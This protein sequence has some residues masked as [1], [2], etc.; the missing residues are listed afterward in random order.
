MLKK[1]PYK[2]FYSAVRKLY[3][4]EVTVYGPYKRKSDGRAIA[5]VYS[6]I[7]GVKTSITKLYAKF[8]LEIKLKR[9]L[10]K[11]ETVGH[12][13]GNPKNDKFINLR[14]LSM[15]ENTR[16]SVK[17]ILVLGVI[18]CVYCSIK[19]IPSQHQVNNRN[20]E[21]AGP[22]CSNTCSG[23]YGTDIQKG[24]KVLKRK[25][26]KVKYYKNSDIT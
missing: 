9:I 12:I 16:H 26:I 21:Q 11:T 3:G 19:F 2:N 6:Y 14:L 5:Q 23:K 25:V 8:K 10:E 22:F 4:T 18:K 7:E 20:S 24:S 1:K 17:R 15:Q 13:D